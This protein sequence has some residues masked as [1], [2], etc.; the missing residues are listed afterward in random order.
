MY[1]RGIE[2]D[3]TTIKYVK[4]HQSTEVRTEVNDENHS[5]DVY[6][7]QTSDLGAI[8]NYPIENIPEYI[9]L[10]KYDTSLI[11]PN[12]S[13][14]KSIFETVEFNIIIA[15]V[16]EE[17]EQIDGHGDELKNVY[18]FYYDR[19]TIILRSD[20]HSL[21]DLKE[22]I[23]DGV[24]GL[25]FSWGD[26]DSSVGNILGV[27]LRNKGNVEHEYLNVD[28]VDFNGEVSILDWSHALEG[29]NKVIYDQL[30]LYE[31]AE[32]ITKTAQEF[33][34]NKN[35]IKY[36][37]NELQQGQVR[38]HLVGPHWKYFYIHK[39]PVEYELVITETATYVRV[40]NL[41]QEFNLIYNIGDYWVTANDGKQ[42]KCAME[43]NFPAGN[44]FDLNDAKG[45]SDTTGNVIR[46]TGYIHFYT[47]TK[48][49][50]MDQI[51]E[52]LA[53]VEDEPDTVKSNSI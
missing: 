17:N 14:R 15:Q 24:P 50:Y 22:L 9:K 31:F 20:K 49:K 19:L 32:P 42:W 23:G 27:N 30:K 46:I 16:D 2:V 7:T 37:I 12:F 35:L 21:N 18:Y 34:E 4:F 33:P 41:I 10:Q 26:L 13:V 40:L 28:P 8:K 39:M 11:L 5:L 52:I 51:L 53:N 38:G 47:V 25:E 6:A 43:W 29:L 48:N 3:N 45:S 1:I 44:N 36:E